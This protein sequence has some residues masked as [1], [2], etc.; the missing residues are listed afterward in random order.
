M[1]PSLLSD[2]ALVSTR[3]SRASPRRPPYRR[4]AAL[5]PPRGNRAAD[6]RRAPDRR[7]PLRPPRHPRGPARRRRPSGHRRAAAARRPPRPRPERLTRLPAA[8]DRTHCPVR[9]PPHR[10]RTRRRRHRHAAAPPLPA[11]F[12][13][14]V[15]A[16]AEAAARARIAT[17]PALAVLLYAYG[18]PTGD[19]LPP[20]AY[21][22]PPAERAILAA[23]RDY[24]RTTTF[25]T[26]DFPAA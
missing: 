8:L 22:L 10:N 17:D 21:S 6:R 25:T 15:N 11:R 26:A 2:A 18:L 1:P 7:R 13:L 3:P 20:S 5:P 16:R 9:T 12:K 23:L 4:N 19:P 24:G 14:S